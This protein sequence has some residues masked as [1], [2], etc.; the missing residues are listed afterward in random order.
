MPQRNISILGSDFEFLGG[1]K[2]ET[3][4]PARY[5]SFADELSIP[6]HLNAGAF[7]QTRCKTHP[8]IFAAQIKDD[9][10]Q[11]GI[12]TQSPVEPCAIEHDGLAALVGVI[13]IKIGI[14]IA[15]GICGGEIGI[16]LAVQH[17]STRLHAGNRFVVVA[18]LQDRGD[19]PP[20][21]NHAN[22]R[23]VVQSVVE[24]PSTREPVLSGDHIASMHI[25]KPQRA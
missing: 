9:V 12:Q 17:G 6:I 5:G 22:L 21:G 8:A 20:V 4:I 24:N 10:F 7:G 3:D 2:R 11:G 23:L 16:S 19:A 15:S 25:G 1:I 14:G 18:T 13:E